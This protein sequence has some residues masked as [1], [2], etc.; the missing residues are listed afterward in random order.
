[1]DCRFRWQ[2]RIQ[3]NAVSRYPEAAKPAFKI[4]PNTGISV[5]AIVNRRPT[6]A[7]IM[8]T[9]KSWLLIGSDISGRT[10]GLIAVGTGRSF[11][12]SILAF[13][14][15]DDANNPGKIAAARRALGRD[16]DPKLP[17]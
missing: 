9:I 16:S 6:A 3:L 12:A 13:G 1:V 5:K 15:I 2:R 7:K 11:F 4:S 17:V 10:N 14:G 8:T